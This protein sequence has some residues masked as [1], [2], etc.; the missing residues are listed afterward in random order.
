V[1]LGG[2][3]PPGP[4][5]PARDLDAGCIAPRVPMP[6]GMAPQDFGVASVADSHYYLAECQRRIAGAGGATG[7][8]KHALAFLLD[9]DGRLI[10]EHDEG[11]LRPGVVVLDNRLVAGNALLLADASLY[12]ASIHGARE[13]GADR[14]IAALS[15]EGIAV[16][17]ASAQAWVGQG[18][19]RAT[20]V[21]DAAAT[22]GWVMTGR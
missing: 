3:M 2:S 22:V 5:N 21:Q 6:V 20:I 18:L 10:P 14:S 11:G 12:L 19:L 1:K 8:R 17:R 7:G 9:R 4:L 15:I 13:R 16:E